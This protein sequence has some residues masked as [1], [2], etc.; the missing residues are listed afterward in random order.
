[1]SYNPTPCQL[2]LVCPWG[3]CFNPI[4]FFGWKNYKVAK[5]SRKWVKKCLGQDKT[6]KFVLV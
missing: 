5:D 2:Q 6:D 3:F 4:T 1:M